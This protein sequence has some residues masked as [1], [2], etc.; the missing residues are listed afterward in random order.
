[1]L[2]ASLIGESISGIEVTVGAETYPMT[3]RTSSVDE[4]IIKSIGEELQRVL[5]W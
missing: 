1:M 3:F 4:E 5:L 2:F